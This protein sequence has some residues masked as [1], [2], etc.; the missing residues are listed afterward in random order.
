MPLFDLYR[1]EMMNTEHEQKIK[2]S[3]GGAFLN[4]IAAIIRF[5][6]MTNHQQE[7]RYK[8]K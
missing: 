2:N 1:T 3:R 5:K 6:K 8:I 4:F 7:L